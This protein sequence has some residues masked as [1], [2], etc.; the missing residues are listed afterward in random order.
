MFG[1]TFCPRSANGRA[2]LG[3]QGFTT[4]ELASSGES[5]TRVTFIAGQGDES[6][7]A[8][9]MEGEPPR[10]PELS[11]IL[12]S[13][14]EAS[15]GE[16]LDATLVGGYEVSSMPDLK[17]SEAWRVARI[18]VTNVAVRSARA[19]FDALEDLLTRIVDTAA[20][21]KQLSRGQWKDAERSSW[22]R[23]VEQAEAG[24]VFAMNALGAS[25]STGMGAPLDYERAA[26]WWR[27]G[28]RE[29]SST[30]PKMLIETLQNN[31]K[32]LVEEHPEF[33]EDG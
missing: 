5:L 23:L 24:D 6:A 22:A 9:A 14:L 11:P 32:R 25:F 4:V 33:R 7:I 15:G 16:T 27:R 12:S 18:S 2:E 1:T 10:V 30:T 19:S 21:R 20:D 8:C 13:V 26:Y 17:C 31:L 28:L 29:A 3:P